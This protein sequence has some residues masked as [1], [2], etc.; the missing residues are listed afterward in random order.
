MF[1]ITILS[2]KDDKDII[3]IVA[4]HFKSI[5]NTTTVTGNVR[6]K[7]GRD[8]LDADTVIIYTN[9]ERKPTSYEASGNVHFTL[10]TTDKR[11]LRGKSKRLTYNVVKDEYRLY[12]DAIVQ[13]VG[14]PNTLKGDEIV[15]AGDGSYANVAG[16]KNT[17]ARIIFSLEK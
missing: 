13:E 17:P 15:L 9:K 5:G 10:I 6:I 16:K 3:D 14:K 11:E 7:K 4:Q 12:D 1:L 2:A 8:T